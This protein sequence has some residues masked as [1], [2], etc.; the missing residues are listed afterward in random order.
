M[1]PKSIKAAVHQSSGTELNDTAFDS[2]VKHLA[3]NR[4]SI[5]NSIDIYTQYM[6][7]GGHVLPRRQLISKVVQK[8]G[9]DM[10]TLSSPGYSM[11]LALQP[12]Y[13]T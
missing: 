8:F 4:G 11:L 3:E 1:S 10:I 7:A 9:R 6:K 13:S 2:D 5:H 12:K